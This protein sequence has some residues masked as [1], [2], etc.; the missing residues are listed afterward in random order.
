MPP[1]RGTAT[2]AA[3]PRRGPPRRA[4]AA[5][6]AAAASAA[7]ANV[8][9]VDAVGNS[10]LPVRPAKRRRTPTAA[11]T[12]VKAEPHAKAEPRAEAEPRAKAKPR[13]KAEP[14][15]KAACH[16]KAEPRAPAS[17]R[18]KAEPRSQEGVR[19][20]CPP[21]ADIEALAPPP[22]IDPAIAAADPWGGV[23]L[24]SPAAAQRVTD[25]LI[26]MYGRPSHVQRNVDA[27]DGDGGGGR[28]VLDALVSTILSQNTTGANSR[29][30][31]AGI[32]A[33]W[34]D[35]WRAVRAAGADALADAIRPGGLAAI[36]AG[37]IIAIL[38]DL[39]AN[40]DRRG[41]GGD[42]RGGG[43]AGAATAVLPP[44]S[45]EHLRNA[46][47]DTAKAALT[48]YPGVGPK[49][50]SCVLLFALDRPE[51]PV[52]THVARLAARLGWAPVIDREVTYA[53]LNAGLPPQ[54]RADLH[55]LLVTHG[56]RRCG[57]RAPR[58]EGC[59]LTADCAFFQKGGVPSDVEKGSSS[60]GATLSGRRRGGD[61]GVDSDD[62]W[63]PA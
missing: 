22:G 32:K 17:A 40:A 4:A 44:L 19:A 48:A 1:S 21:V 47:S 23:Y 45:L 30:A 15:A 2:V 27:P 8:G 26:L 36:K 53:S 49:T 28:S 29:R 20:G 13:A 24:P 52:D 56:R 59:A 63:K 60:N 16:A 33:R 14:R 38:D 57:A 50:A 41:A 11:G 43:E 18:V 62:S 6:A 61:V 37:R 12:R 9:D 5:A 34:G 42:H 54:L 7:A 25:G 58:C 31:F 51:F 10:P 39:A 3:V 46:D 55:V 35:D